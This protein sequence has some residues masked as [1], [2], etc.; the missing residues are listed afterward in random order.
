MPI[1]DA[2][3]VRPDMKVYRAPG[4]YEVAVLVATRQLRD[5]GDEAGAYSRLAEM[6]DENRHRH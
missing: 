3:A 1:G 6:A 4:E 5:E 2:R